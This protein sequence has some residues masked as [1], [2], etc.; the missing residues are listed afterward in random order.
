MLEA[1][2]RAVRHKWEAR[3]KERGMQVLLIPRVS[4]RLCLSQ[5]RAEM[6]ARIPNDWSASFEG[7]LADDVASYAANRTPSARLEA[8][9][10]VNPAIAALLAWRDESW[11]PLRGPLDAVRQDGFDMLFIEL[12]GKCNERCVHCYAD[13]GPSVRNAL[14]RETCEAILD[15]AALL[16][17]RRVQFTGGDPLL[18]DF[19]PELL[20]RAAQYDFI[21]RE[22]YTNGLLLDDDLL[23]RLAPHRPSFAFSYYSHVAATHDAITRTRGSHARTRAAIAR[24]VAR[25]LPVRAAV[26][27]MAENATDVEGAVADLKSLGV[28]TIHVANTVAI[29]RG[30]QQETSGSEQTSAGHRHGDAGRQGKLAITWSGDV[31]PC[32]FN[33]RR[34]LGQIGSSRLRDIMAALDGSRSNCKRLSV[35]APNPNT[36]LA[37]PSCRLT[38]DL[39][40][41]VGG[42]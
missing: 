14:D 2:A 24:V 40:G 6:A 31:V 23:D 38:D 15:D 7:A 21:A 20:E 28:P 36:G 39:L 8:L 30:A 11:L 13:A 37:C 27:A 3:R 1:P 32:I 35:M 10:R 19:L 41:V 18:C 29:G 5:G 12:L 25:G 17:F 26:I 33:R 16:G 34:V 4:A 9:A 22:I 42:L